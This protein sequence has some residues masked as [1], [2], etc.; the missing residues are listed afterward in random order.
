MNNPNIVIFILDVFLDGC[1]FFYDN[2]LV[3]LKDWKV[4]CR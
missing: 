4:V 3:P 1:F 2:S